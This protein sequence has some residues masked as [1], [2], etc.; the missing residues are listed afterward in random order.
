MEKGTTHPSNTLLEDPKDTQFNGPGLLIL[1][2]HGKEYQ[3]RFD[4]EDFEMI[5]DYQWKL[6][7]QGYAMARDQGKTIL[8]H[9]LIMGVVDRETQVDHK[10]HNKLDNRKI[11]LRVCSCTENRRNSQK[12]KENAQSSFKGVYKDGRYFHVQIK[13]GQKTKNIGRFKCEN[14]AGKRYDVLARQLF[15]EYACLNFPDYRD[16]EQLLI[17]WSL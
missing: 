6:H 17:Q 3:C 13:Q 5:C 2:S 9:R 16:P 4:P 7:S 8:M 1:K 11:Y 14:T 10:F 12:H 15:G